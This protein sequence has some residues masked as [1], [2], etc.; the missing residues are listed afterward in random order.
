M[1]TELGQQ[2]MQQGKLEIALENLNKALSFDPGYVDAHT[3]IAV[4]YERIGDTPSRRD[5]TA[6]R[7]S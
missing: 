6:A 4:L 1:H 2:Y 3:V 7:R 5:I